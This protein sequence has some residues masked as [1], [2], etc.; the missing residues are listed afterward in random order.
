MVGVESV[1]LSRLRR[2]ELKLARAE[3]VELSWLIVGRRI[4]SFA[5][6]PF[7]YSGC[8]LL[9]PEYTHCSY[10]F[11]RYSNAC[12]KS[13]LDR[14]PGMRPRAR[15]N[16]VVLFFKNILCLCTPNVFCILYCVKTFVDRRQAR[17]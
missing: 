12:R 14:S 13:P 15:K 7:A 5:L 4:E 2:A 9:E 1:E 17:S 8:G 10:D 3:R 11:S 16:A 6:L